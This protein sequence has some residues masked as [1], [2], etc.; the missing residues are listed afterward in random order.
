MGSERQYGRETMSNKQI[1]YAVDFDGTLCTNK[2]P[3]IGLENMK[4]IEFLKSE[5]KAGNKV[6]LNT[7]REGK[8]LEAALTWC[9]RNGLEFDAMND[10]LPEMQKRFGSNP[11]KI[12]A[13]YYIDDHNAICD[14]GIPLERYKEF[15]PDGMPKKLGRGRRLRVRGK[16][17][18]S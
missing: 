17:G 16:N 12:Y 10:N 6:I 5:R 2:W 14:I 15:V 11:R 3:D 4:L 8:L 18:S 1:I 13:D 9:R 7:M